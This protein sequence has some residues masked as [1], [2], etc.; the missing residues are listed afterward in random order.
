MVPVWI[1]TIVGC[2]A[3]FTLSAPAKFLAII[4]EFLIFHQLNNVVYIVPAESKRSLKGDGC[5][6]RRR[7]QTT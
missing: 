2:S 7:K 1:V 3:D 4:I 5:E 6:T